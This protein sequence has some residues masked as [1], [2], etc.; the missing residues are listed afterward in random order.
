[1]IAGLL[2]F[3]LFA[4]NACQSVQTKVVD[5]VVVTSSAQVVDTA[6]LFRAIIDKDGAEKA[7]KKLG[8][9]YRDFGHVGVLWDNGVFDLDASNARVELWQEIA[10]GR[11]KPTDT[12]LLG[13]TIDAFSSSAAR[14]YRDWGVIPENCQNLKMQFNIYRKVTV[15]NETGQRMTRVL[16]AGN[17][18][19][20]TGPTNDPLE[21]PD[22]NAGELR[23][24]GAATKF[25]VEFFGFS[26]YPQ[27]RLEALGGFFDWIAARQAQE[28][29]L[30]GQ[31]IKQFESTLESEHPEW[32][33]GS[34]V[35][36]EQE[37]M[38]LQQEMSGYT[39]LD[40]SWAKFK[41]VS[42]EPVAAFH[43]KFF[44]KKNGN[45]T[46]YGGPV[47]EPDRPKEPKPIIK[48]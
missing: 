14:L 41:V 22:R 38:A 21:K 6:E 36:N 11:I 31:A 26:E 24:T 25:A 30:I 28:L 42:T 9:Y 23:G 18:N 17:P 39:Q 2:S 46:M 10:Q 12:V 8:Y 37:L 5:L 32:V 1:M 15:E 20:S 3:Q 4:T 35:L 40:P 16:L 48:P 43:L 27:R 47:L 7:L 19:G 45:L 34:T 29:S 44:I 33:K 13:D